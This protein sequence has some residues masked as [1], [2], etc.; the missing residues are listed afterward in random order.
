MTLR[1]FFVS[2]ISDEMDRERKDG[3][4]GPFLD[5]S[6][7]ARHPKTFKKDEKRSDNENNGRIK[8]NPL[9]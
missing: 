3:K 7:P 6:I 4:K 1:I 9:A 2:G 5:I 8:V